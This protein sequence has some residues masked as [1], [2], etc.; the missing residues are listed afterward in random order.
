MSFLL[1]TFFIEE[2]QE[3][4][5]DDDIALVAQGILQDYR[6]GRI[7]ATATFNELLKLRDIDGDF[8]PR[9]TQRFGDG[10]LVYVLLLVR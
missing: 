8:F 5:Q 4:M 6:S 9:M 1:T 2:I 10:W 3:H 7:D